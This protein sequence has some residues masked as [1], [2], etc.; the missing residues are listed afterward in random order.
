MQGL[1]IA[2]YQ[3]LHKV[4]HRMCATHIYGNMKKNLPKSSQMKKLF[5]RI[6]ES[7]NE[8]DYKAHLK[9]LK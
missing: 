2:V 7:L 6:V 5:W 3:K 9:A 1:L 4:E 8:P